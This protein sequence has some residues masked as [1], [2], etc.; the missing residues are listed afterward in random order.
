MY[1]SGGIWKNAVVNGTISP[2]WSSRDGVIEEGS[3]DFDTVYT[4]KVR[5]FIK[6]ANTEWNKYG[7]NELYLNGHILK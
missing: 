5:L 2:E 4:T 1:F 7:I 6:A 3:M